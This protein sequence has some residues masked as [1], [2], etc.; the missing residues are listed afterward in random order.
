MQLF[1]T[2]GFDRTTVDAI[3]AASG[4]SRR[5]LFRYFES[6]EDMT[7]F[8]TA[9]TGQEL[10]SHLGDEEDNITGKPIEACI[11]AVLRHVDQNQALH[12]ISLD[13]GRLIEQTPSLKNRKYQ[14]YLLW[15]NL[16]AEALIQTGVNSSTSR[17]AAALA[18]S[19]L[20]I[21][22]EQ[23]LACDGQQKITDILRE[24]YKPFIN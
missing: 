3:A 24:V 14:K 5:S 11:N 21:A 10:I 2:D 15:E 1:L 23:W 18:L 6:K 4:V 17:M 20:R 13:V 22:V 7:M 8:W 9:S 12:N 16:M 19:G